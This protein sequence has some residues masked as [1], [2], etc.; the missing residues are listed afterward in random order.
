MDIINDLKIDNN[1]KQPLFESQI[2]SDEEFKS[3]KTLEKD[4]EQQ[5]PTKFSNLKKA[6]FSV[7]S[8]VFLIS[9]LLGGSLIGAAA[10]LIKPESAWILNTWG[11]GLGFCYT[12]LPAIA[13]SFLT[14]GYKQKVLEGCTKKNFLLLLCTPFLHLIWHWGLFYG[15]ERIVQSHAYVCVCLCSIWAL[16]MGWFFRGYK[17][18]RIEV[19]GLVL[20][21]GG[22][23]IMFADPTAVRTD[24][25]TGTF[26]VYALCIATSIA[27]ALF[28]V[29]NDILCQKIPLV[30]L[31]LVQSFLCFWSCCM[32]TKIIEP[33]AVLFS[34]DPVWG[35]FGFLSGE[36][37]I[38]NLFVFGL[39]AGFFGNT[40][41]VI[42][43]AF[44]SPAVISATFLLEPAIAQFLGW[45]TGVDHLPSYMTWIGTALVMLGIFL[46]Q[47]ADKSRRAQED[48]SKV[49][50]IAQIDVDDLESQ[51]TKQI[52]KIVEGGF[53]NFNDLKNCDTQSVSTCFT[54]DDQ[55]QSV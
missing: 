47:E 14:E 10:N 49:I 21:V 51:A 16:F 50:E 52:N 40:G 3:A 54:N 18:F 15:A 12:I 2:D 35:C 34:V 38:N 31:V 46:I 28:F 8:I 39:S 24:G 37:V 13:E 55:Y 26:S 7:F 41:Y 22:V 9:C 25:K 42:S 6:L 19:L 11:Y 1:L 30:L 27:G 5:E 43:L 20:T 33:Q 44:F 29:I 4:T 32:L 45:M 23:V 53:L 48:K 36:D 17:A